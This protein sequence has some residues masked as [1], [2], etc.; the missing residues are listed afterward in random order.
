[1]PR[2]P[3][4]APS[5]T[6]SL[7][8]RLA[9]YSAS[10]AEAKSEAESPPSASAATPAEHVTRSPSAKRSS[11]RPET[12]RAAAAVAELSPPRT[13]S[14]SSSPPKRAAT[15][16][17]RAA[18]RSDA[19]RLA[20][21]LVAGRVAVAVVD[22]LEV[23]EVEHD[24]RDLAAVALHAPQLDLERLVEELRPVEAGQRIH[25]R[26]PLEPAP[27]T[28][29][30][31]RGDGCGA[32]GGEQRDAQPERHGQRRGQRCEHEPGR[33]RGRRQHDRGRE[34]DGVSGGTTTAAR[35]P[36]SVSRSA[37]AR[38]SRSLRNRASSTL[39]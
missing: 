20:Q 32:G 38:A 37:A 25:E 3:A 26:A 18:L 36:H 1:M 34:Q 2:P 17:S 33:A 13:S 27:V 16:E 35:A 30:Q 24:E 31:R 5:T 12:T 21:H 11:R 6:R 9:S 8:R 22:L 28:F 14:T 19:A 4:G 10:S 7:P 15:S 29:G 23:V 39:L